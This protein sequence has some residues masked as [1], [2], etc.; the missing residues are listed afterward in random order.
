MTS[1]GYFTS[2]KIEKRERDEISFE[3]WH[4]DFTF[5]HRTL[6]TFY[7]EKMEKGPRGLVQ[8]Q[9]YNMDCYREIFVT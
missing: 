5:H 4:C 3:K 2:G 7:L 9:C 1:H 8:T 6:L